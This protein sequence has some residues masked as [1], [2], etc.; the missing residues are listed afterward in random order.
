MFDMNF[1][2]LCYHYIRTEESTSL[3]PRVLGNT[4]SD[5]RAHLTMLKKEYCL[6]SPDQ[7]KE[8]YYEK[9]EIS[10]SPHAEGMLLTFDDGLSDHYHA[11]KILADLDIKGIFFIPTCAL[12]EK[13]P[14]NPQI[15]HYSIA[16]Y[17]VSKFLTAYHASLKKYGLHDAPEYL[18][19]FLKE[20]NPFN[21]IARIKNIFKYSLPFKIAREILLNIYNELL[22]KD[23][24]NILNEIHLSQEKIQEMI[25]M[26]H[27]IGVHSHSHLSVAASKL[28]AEDFYTEI[29]NPRNY[30]EKT[31]ATTID[32]LSYPFGEKEDCLNAGELIA[33]TSLFKL[34]FTV[35]TIVNSEKTNPFELG[36]YMP[37]S[38]DDP[39]KLKRILERIKEQNT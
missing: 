23:F 10:T 28:S 13:L 16:H 27:T 5:F 15:I 20:H 14:A 1:L 24:P 35:E 22:L 8:H 2:S 31:F 36:R 38:T 18:I 19:P 32:T 39:E 29:I 21:A 12:I 6:L 30:L 25:S 4:E 7:I 17:G 9:K 26:G 3:F 34:A 33:N 37:M 11:A